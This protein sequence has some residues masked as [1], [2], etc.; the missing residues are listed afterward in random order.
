[1]TGVGFVWILRPSLP[2]PLTCCPQDWVTHLSPIYRLKQDFM[3]AYLVDSCSGCFA[4]RDTPLLPLPPRS[5]YSL[6]R[7]SGES[8]AA[9]PHGSVPLPPAPLYSWP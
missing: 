9:T 4:V 1:M 8:R 5:R 7:L 2:W 3:R 6:E